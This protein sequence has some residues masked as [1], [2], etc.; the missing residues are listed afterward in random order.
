MDGNMIAKLKDK[1]LEVKFTFNSFLF[2]EDFNVK[3]LEEVETKPFKMLG[4][5]RILLLGGFNHND[6]IR[7]GL[8]TVDAFLQEYM[9][10]GSIGDLMEQIMDELY[11]SDFF[12]SLQKKTEVTE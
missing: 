2:M 4:V 6:K 12:K 9:V 3:D 5:L 11:K 7:Y 1:E 8:A 10:E